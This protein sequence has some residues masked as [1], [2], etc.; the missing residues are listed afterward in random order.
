MAKKPSGTPALRA[1]DAARVAYTVREYAHDPRA[2]SFGLEA[3]AALGLPPGRVF[4]TLLASDGRQLVVGIVPVDRTLDLKALAVALGLKKLAMADPAAAER[5][6]GMVV[7]GIS[8]IGQKRALPTVL[9]AS[10][11]EYDTVLVSGGRRGLDVELAP[12]DLVRLTAAT[13]HP[14]ADRKAT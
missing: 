1:L 4:K 11:V 9:D 3:A 10:A 8:P 14:I 12:A 2:V 7:G 13:V 5:S 6:S